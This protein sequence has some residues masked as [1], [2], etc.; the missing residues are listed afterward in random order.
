MGKNSRDG[1][2]LR[3]KEILRCM[4]AQ[5]N[6][7]IDDLAERVGASSVTIRRDINELLAKKMVIRSAAGRFSLLNDPAFDERYFRRY[8][9]QHAEKVAIARAAIDLVSDGMVL[10]LDSSSTCLEFGKLLLQKRDITLVT[11]NLFLPHYLMGHPSLHLN[12]VGGWVHLS[13]NSTEGS[14]AC[15]EIE[16]FNYD[17]V[18][19]SASALDFSSGLSNGD[20]TAI[21]S[22]LSFIRNAAKR[23]LLMDSTKFAQKSSRN[24]MRL[25]EISMVVTDAGASPEHLAEFSRLGIPCLVAE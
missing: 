21:E 12:C 14:S 22:K 10:G 24:F 16:R 7:T 3:R 4:S 25:S 1:I 19:F 5:S 20:A 8:S 18:F 6:L 11:N 13:S 9:A 23:V 15:R 2:E 17:V